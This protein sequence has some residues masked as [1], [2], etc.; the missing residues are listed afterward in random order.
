MVQ[1][2]EDHVNWN[3][4]LFKRNLFLLIIPTYYKYLPRHVGSTR[5]NHLPMHFIRLGCNISDFRLDNRPK[6]NNNLF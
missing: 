5:V 1:F 4:A 3:G 6:Y 2:T